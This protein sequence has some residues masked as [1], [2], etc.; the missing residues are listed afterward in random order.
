MPHLKGAYVVRESDVPHGSAPGGLGTVR[1]TINR[2]IGCRNLVQRVLRY[3][4]GTR[5]ESLNPGEE[6][7]LFVLQ[8]R[9]EAAIGGRECDLRPDMGV[10]V[11]PGVRCRVASRGP[12]ELVLLSAVSPQPGEPPGQQAEARLRE[13]GRLWVSVEEEEDIPAGDDRRFK[14]L[15][16]PRYG[17]RNLTQF[18]GVIERSRAPFHSHTYEEVIYIVSGDG[19]VH[20][21]DETHPIRRGT[22]IYLPPGLPHCLENSGEAP[23]TLV[24]TFC[25]AGD[26]G[27]KKEG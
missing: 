3:L 13:D 5:G 21:D 9:G 2:A 10:L 26:P 4:P 15:I 24:G 18:V 19:V 6:E 23:L 25:P 20:V 27:S 17:C 14:L 22:C 16:D 7:V 8:G 12:G 1:E 11:P